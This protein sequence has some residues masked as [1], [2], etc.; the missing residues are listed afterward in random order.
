MEVE[1]VQMI[2]RVEGGQSWWQGWIKQKWWKTEEG[3]V[4]KMWAQQREMVGAMKRLQNKDDRDG[5]EGWRMKMMEMV[6]KVRQG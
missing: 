2:K 4:V 3:I 1:G 5:R 6:E